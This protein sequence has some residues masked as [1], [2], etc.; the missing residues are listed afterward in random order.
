MGQNCQRKGK[1]GSMF[2]EALTKCTIELRLASSL[3]TKHLGS[4][5]E[6][7]K[8]LRAKFEVAADMTNPRCGV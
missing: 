5:L 2:L 1:F 6:A 3:S 4:I 7:S 8:V